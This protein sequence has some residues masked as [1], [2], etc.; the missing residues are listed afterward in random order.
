[1]QVQGRIAVILAAL[2]LLVSPPATL[3]RGKGAP[4]SP[5]VETEFHSVLP[6]GSASFLIAGQSAPV[7]LMATAVSRDLE[8]WKEIDQGGSRFLY[9][10]DGQR[11]RLYPRQMQ[12]RVTASAVERVP[13]DDDSAV[14]KSKISLNDYLLRLRFQL[15]IFHGLGMHVLPP[16]EVHLVGVPSDVP[17]H[18]RIFRLNFQLPPV[19]VQDRMVLEVLSP[20]GQRLARFHFELM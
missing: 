15:R 17:Y 5:T 16:A 1:M 19:P 8:G 12:F 9:T 7:I 4:S 10:N 14:V 18:E 2:T 11:A 6:L 3:G 20:E 13:A